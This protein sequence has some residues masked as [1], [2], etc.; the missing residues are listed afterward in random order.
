MHEVSI[1]ESLISEVAAAARRHGLS[2]VRGVGVCVGERS[3]VAPHA[4]TFAFELMREGP[5]LGSAVLD[6]RSVDGPDLCLEWIE[7]E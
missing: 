2:A 1:A 3:G 5:I 6:V 7:G 4:L